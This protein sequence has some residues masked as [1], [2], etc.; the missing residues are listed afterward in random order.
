MEGWKGVEGFPGRVGACGGNRRGA[1]DGDDGGGGGAVD[2]VCFARC[3]LGSIQRSA[4]GWRLGGEPVRVQEGG[5]GWV[6]V[7]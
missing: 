6:V 4:V 7:W 3:C 1:A 5:R 2:C